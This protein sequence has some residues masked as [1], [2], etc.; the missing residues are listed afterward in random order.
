MVLHWW[1]GNNRRKSQTPRL[2]SLAN[3]VP[4][5]PGL[6]CFWNN[7]SP[8]PYFLIIPRFIFRFFFIGRMRLSQGFVRQWL[9]GNASSLGLACKKEAGGE[10]I[11]RGE[12][13]KEK[14]D[15]RL[16]T[17]IAK[18]FAGNPK[19]FESILHKIVLT[20]AKWQQSWSWTLLSHPLWKRNMRGSCYSIC[21]TLRPSRITERLW[22]W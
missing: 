3:V 19:G 4:L 6:Q 7:V 1:L 21:L 10:G 8:Q 15:K 18:C 13:G 11:G 5:H 17:S 14:Q 16:W 20:I 22:G 12:K 9:W 2:T